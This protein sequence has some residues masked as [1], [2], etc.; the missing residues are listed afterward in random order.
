MVAWE[1]CS[2]P[3][4]RSKNRF[5]YTCTPDK[6]TIIVSLLQQ[7]ARKKVQTPLFLLEMQQST[8]PWQPV[9]LKHAR[10]FTAHPGIICLKKSFRM[11]G[12]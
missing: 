5:F 1:N 11:Y 6:S 8:N 9:L 12:W 4:P 7:K 10:N 3:Y 2:G